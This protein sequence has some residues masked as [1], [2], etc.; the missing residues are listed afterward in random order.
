MRI[1]VLGCSGA[2]FPGHYPPGFLID[3]RILLDA[4]TLNNV[5]DAKCQAKVKD[6]FITHAH[7][8]HIREIPFLADNI[9]IGGWK[10]KVRIFS[11]LPVIR[12]IKKNLLNFKL[13][14]DMTVLPNAHDGVIQLNALQAGRPHEIHGYT[15]TPY[16]VNHSVPAVGYLV[17]GPRSR[18]FFYTGDTGPTDSLWN[19]IGNKPLHGLII[20][21]SFPNRM[22]EIARMT[23]H[24]TPSLLAKEL[25]KMKVMPERI[26]ITH[27]K[28]QFYKTIQAELK[29]LGIRSLHLLK[30]GETLEI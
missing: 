8:D 9:I 17:E 7:M 11:I 20:E 21:T 22:E 18:R 29:R 27:L 13:W 12:D 5:L 23:G 16:K 26:Y 2:E 1:E 3:R 24:L 10:H 25:L 15:L 6:I 4:G 19:R 14:P 28:P 30:E